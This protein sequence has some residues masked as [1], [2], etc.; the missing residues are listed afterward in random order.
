MDQRDAR[1]EFAAFAELAARH[2]VAP[3]GPATGNLARF[4]FNVYSQNGEDGVLAEIFRRIGPGGMR[5]IEIGAE[6]WQSNAIAL[7]DLMGWGGTFVDAVPA[8]VEAFRKK[9][10][11]FAGIDA[12]EAMVTPEWVREF[13]ATGPEELDLLSI[14]VDGNDFW[15]WAAF[16][17]MRP[18]VVMIEYN[19]NPGPHLAVVQPE[20]TAY[21]EWH[22]DFFGAS[23]KALMTLAAWKGYTLVHTESRGVNAFF[24]RDDLLWAFADLDL[25]ALPLRAPSIDGRGSHHGADRTGRQYLEVEGDEVRQ[26]VAR[27][28]RPLAARSVRALALGGH[29]TAANAAA[30]SAAGN[31]GADGFRGEPALWALLRPGMNVLDIG[32]GVGQATLAMAGLVGPEG[33]VLAIEPDPARAAALD[34]AISHAGTGNVEALP[35]PIEGMHDDPG[36]SEVPAAHVD[37]LVSADVRIHLVHIGDGLRAH[38]IASRMEAFIRRQGPTVVVACEARAGGDDL[39]GAFSGYRSMGLDVALAPETIEALLALPGGSAEGWWFSPAIPAEHDRA[40]ADL[41]A[42]AGP[43]TL[44]LRP[45]PGGFRPGQ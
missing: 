2:A 20:S 16:E 22:W 43:A 10:A 38:R 17:R 32:A 40:L 6:P 36:A 41:V 29:R 30:A 12:I 8:R 45:L 11:G 1:L 26:A 24:V 28:P 14:D 9:Y 15:I 5:F 27:L 42:R 21:V 23:A 25:A 35:L 3:A 31:P 34:A 37:D 19:S 33:R 44:V 13:D 18:R 7:A 39:A 4:E